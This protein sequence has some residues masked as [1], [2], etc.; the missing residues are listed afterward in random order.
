M[1]WEFLRVSVADPI[2]SFKGRDELIDKTV[3]LALI[4]PHFSLQVL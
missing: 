1:T 2:L 3:K 4:R